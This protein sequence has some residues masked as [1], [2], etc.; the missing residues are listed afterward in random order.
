MKRDN[1]GWMEEKKIPTK[2]KDVPPKPTPNPK[3]KT[4]RG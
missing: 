3:D 4:V 1:E 2:K